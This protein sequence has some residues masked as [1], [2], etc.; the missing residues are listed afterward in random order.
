MPYR[1]ASTADVDSVMDEAYGGMWFLRDALDGD[2]LGVT[3][4][5]LEPG[6]RGKEHDHADDGQ[7]EVYVCVE[8]AVDVDCDGETVTL[9]DD[10]ALGLS[11]DQTR[12][13]HNRGDDRAKLVL[14]GGP[15]E[16]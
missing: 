11:P 8:G 7:E 1:K 10:E 6:A 16:E 12:T 5:E 13:I 9:H 3:I 2:D 15:T 4:M 14:V